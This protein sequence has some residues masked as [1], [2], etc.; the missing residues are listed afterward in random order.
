M[1][2]QFEGTSPVQERHRFDVAALASYPILVEPVLTL[3]DQTRL[4][5]IVYAAF[6]LLAGACAAFA[7]RRPVGL[8]ARG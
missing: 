5:T 8:P 6:V 2:E 7:W 3:R 4:W 1:F